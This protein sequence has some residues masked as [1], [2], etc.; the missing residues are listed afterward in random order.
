MGNDNI[1]NYPPPNE[2]MTDRELKIKADGVRLAR[3]H[4]WKTK[5]TLHTS[6][7]TLAAAIEKGEA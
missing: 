1:I 6:L 2:F 7:T 5:G 4:I 3:D